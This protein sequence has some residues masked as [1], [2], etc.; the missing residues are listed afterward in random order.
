MI[1]AYLSTDD[2]LAY[3]ASLGVQTSRSGLDLARQDGRLT[4]I[5]ARGR[6]RIL[7]RPEDLRA[8]DGLVIPGGE[9]SVMDKLSRLF[10]LAEPLRSAGLIVLRVIVSS[11]T[12]WW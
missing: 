11:R 12:G 8:V 6:V 5:R 1:P 9:S 2:A 3:L 7:Y 10:D 4:C